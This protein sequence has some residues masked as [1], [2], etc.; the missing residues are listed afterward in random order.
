MCCLKVIRAHSSAVG[1]RSPVYD[2]KLVQD[3]IDGGSFPNELTPYDLR[4]QAS[5]P[6]AD[7][8]KKKRQYPIALHSFNI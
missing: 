2:M 8:G 4:T 1:F 3:A 7:A 6:S 5:D